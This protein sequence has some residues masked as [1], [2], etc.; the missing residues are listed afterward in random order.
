MHFD[1]WYAP[2][3]YT[4][5]C[6]IWS[7]CVFPLFFFLLWYFTICSWCLSSWWY[8]WNSHS[9]QPVFYYFGKCR[10]YPPSSIWWSSSQAACWLTLQ[11]RWPPPVASALCSLPLPFCSYPLPQH[12]TQPWHLVDA[13]SWWFYMSSIKP[14][15]WI[16]QISS[17]AIQSTLDFCTVSHWLHKPVQRISRTW[18]KFYHHSTLTQIDS[19]SA[20]ST[21]FWFCPNV[22]SPYAIHC[23]RLAEGMALCLGYTWL[24]AN[25]QTL[26]QWP[27]SSSWWCGSHHWNIYHQYLCHPGHVLGWSSLLV[28]LLADD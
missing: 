16:R 1:K 26:H 21:I 12:L 18:M 14:C 25:L 10:L 15:I 19:T 22:L 3:K 2:G 11:W 27:C 23:L 9:R 6:L 17:T 7:K 24:Y 28:A 4:R 5:H 8:H 20:W 13:H